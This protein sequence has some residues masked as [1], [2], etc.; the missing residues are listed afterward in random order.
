METISRN[1][2]TF[3]LLY[4]HQHIQQ[5]IT[6]MAH[7]INTYYAHLQQQQQSLDLVLVCILKGAFMFFS[8]LVKEITHSHTCEFIKCRSYEGF[9]STGSVMF[10]L[11]PKAEDFAGKN[12]LLVDDIHDTGRTL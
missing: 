7:Q 9:E 4:P 11:E 3:R 6:K 10:A 1:A 2:L 5:V 12:V 8:D